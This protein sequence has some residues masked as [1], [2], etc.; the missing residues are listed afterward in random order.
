MATTE[1]TNKPMFP[2]FGGQIGFFLKVGDFA[3]DETGGL[4]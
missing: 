2:N 1:N 3:G 4:V